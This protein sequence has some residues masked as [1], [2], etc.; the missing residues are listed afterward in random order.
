MLITPGA[1]IGGELK[2]LSPSGAFFHCCTEPEGGQPLR[3]VFRDPLR[4]K[5]IVVPAE[6]AWSNIANSDDLISCGI[7]IEFDNPLSY[8]ELFFDTWTPENLQVTA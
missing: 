3:L 5:L 2:N 7:G 8:E 1:C 6:L 4:K